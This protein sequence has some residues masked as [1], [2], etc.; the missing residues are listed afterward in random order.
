MSKR[1]LA[2]FSAVFLFVTGA[3]AASLDEPSKAVERI[4]GKKFLLPVRQVEIDRAQL[5]QLLREQMA[6]SLPYS[7]DEW[8]TILRALQL[9]DRDTKDVIPKLI[10]L[11]ESQILAF[12][13]AQTHI[14]YSIREPP[15]AA[16]KLDDG[17][18]LEETVVIHE[19]AHAMQDQNFGIGAKDFALR[20][21]TDA[22]F[23][24]H[25]LLEG[26]A[27]LVMM[28]YLIE[29]G[30]ADF[31]AL[32]RQD[33]FANALAM[34][35]EGDK[36]IDASTPRYFAE[37]L[38]FPY[39]DG[40]RFVIAA[41]R[42]GG[43]Q[44]LDRV[45][46]DPPRSTREILHPEDYLERRFRAKLFT[47][48]LP[49]NALTVEHLGEYH[50]AFMVGKENAR[51]WIDDRVVITMNDLCEPLVAVVTTW[52]SR[53]RADAFR[54]AYVAFLRGRG[55]EPGVEQEGAVVKVRYAPA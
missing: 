6:K 24:Y 13:D 50:W 49:A 10:S 30:G 21:D 35:A 8:V 5:P 16:R 26:E 4:R 36:S 33:K 51:G 47:A 31:D 23:A 19:L 25:A 12:Y 11:Y 41:Y 40:L 20:A 55:I 1:F 14:Y 54:D 45:H 9:V 22:A 27:S 34:A 32:V 28:A 44:E 42:R 52:E 18:M 46:A 53:E 43:W 37:A 3:A 39:I 7:I 15:I 2:V 38:R 17:G 48:N 29:K